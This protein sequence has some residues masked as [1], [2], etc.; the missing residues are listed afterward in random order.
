MANTVA[1]LDLEKEQLKSA[2]PSQDVP[3]NAGQ[4]QSVDGIKELLSARDKCVVIRGVG[5]RLMRG[6]LAVSWH[7]YVQ[8][9]ARRTHR[10]IYCAGKLTL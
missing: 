3:D 6:E 9:C 2:V 8:S 7:K 4:R 1:A 5:L 10:M